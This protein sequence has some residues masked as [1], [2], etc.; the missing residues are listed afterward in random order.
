[1]RADLIHGIGVEVG[2]VQKLHIDSTS[3]S[4]V[5]SFIE[6]TGSM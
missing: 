4:K 6:N 2:F 3:V 5:R 1:M